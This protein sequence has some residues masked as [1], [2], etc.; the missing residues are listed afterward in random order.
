VNI[1]F[2]KTEIAD[3]IFRRKFKALKRKVIAINL[4]NARSIGIIY[5]ATHEINFNK[6]KG[7]VKALK[8]QKKKV[9]AMGFINSKT[10]QAYHLAK[11]EF[12][13]FS[14]ADLNW[15]SHSK[16][17]IIDNFINTKF[18]ILIDLNFDNCRPAYYIAA[19]SQS[20]FKLGKLSPENKLI[21]DL[22]IDI[23]PS[24]NNMDYFISQAQHYL[25]IINPNEQKN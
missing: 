16:S 21:H 15:Y 20:S 7:W 5:D 19:L 18:D 6:V 13:F 12:D 22:L 24:A 10:L 9:K 17:S 4:Q 23:N 25:Q 11:L 2:I 3:F 8:D 1:S 14:E